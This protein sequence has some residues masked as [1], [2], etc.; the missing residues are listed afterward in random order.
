MPYAIVSIDGA[1]P[2]ARYQERPSRVYTPRR[3]WNDLSSVSTTRIEHPNSIP[4]GGVALPYSGLFA[5]ED[6]ASD[7]LDAVIARLSAVAAYYY[8]YERLSRIT[9][10][11]YEWDQTY[12]P[13]AWARIYLVVE[14]GDC[15][16]DEVWL[17]PKKV[18]EL[19][20]EAIERA[21]EINGG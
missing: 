9:A 13:T 11:R 8:R 20:E 16:N 3:L 14:K 1:P 6:L 12:Y 21:S 19:T 10:V 17:A 2:K 5:T 18:R 7:A 15:L 4:F